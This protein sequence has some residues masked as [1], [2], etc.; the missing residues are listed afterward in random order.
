MAGSITPKPKLKA[1]KIQPPLAL[2]SG[3]LPVV[4]FKKEL[5]TEP[6]PNNTKIKVPKNSVKYLSIQLCSIDTFS[7]LEKI[8]EK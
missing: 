5:A 4:P 8:S 2:P 6:L 3:A 1:T 7:S